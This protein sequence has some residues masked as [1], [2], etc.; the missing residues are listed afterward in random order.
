MNANILWHLRQFLL[1][2][3]L[4]C[5]LWLDPSLSLSSVKITFYLSFLLLLFTLIFFLH[6]LSF[7]ISITCVFS[8]CSFINIFLLLIVLN[9]TSIFY[10]SLLF[11][12]TNCLVNSHLYLSVCPSVSFSLPFLFFLVL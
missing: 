3:I 7:F 1:Q 5:Q 9:F 8:K 10:F 12:D 6:I 2:K 11:A 4:L